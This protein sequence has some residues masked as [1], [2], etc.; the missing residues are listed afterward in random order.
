MT[1]LSKDK[2]QKLNKMKE[3]LW[4]YNEASAMIA[5]AN[6]VGHECE[7]VFLVLK[8]FQELRKGLETDIKELEPTAFDPVE[9]EQ[10]VGE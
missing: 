9:T 3:S 2:A 10:A 1:A 5:H 4:L 7:K 8:F 6:F